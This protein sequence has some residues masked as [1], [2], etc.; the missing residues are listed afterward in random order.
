MVANIRV[1]FTGYNSNIF[2]FFLESVNLFS[3]YSPIR[4]QVGYWLCHPHAIVLLTI[5]ELLINNIQLGIWKLQGPRYLLSDRDF[6]L[7]SCYALH[8]GESSD[9]KERQL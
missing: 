3:I 4:Q 8:V 9:E 6:F 2:V 7:K 1:F 5:K